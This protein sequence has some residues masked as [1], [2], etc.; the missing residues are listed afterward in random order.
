MFKKFKSNKYI[1]VIS[2]VIYL[3]LCIV[4][5]SFGSVKIPFTHTIRVILNMLFN[6]GDISD[7]PET[8]ITIITNI[9]LPR[10][11]MASIV[12]S[13]LSLAG[14]VMQGLLKNPLADGSSLGVASGASIGATIAIALGISLPIFSEFSI[15]IT[16]IIFAFISLFLVLFAVKKI[17]S[18]MSTNTVILAGVIFSMFASSISSLILA[19]FSNDTKKIVFWTLGSLASSNMSKVLLILP[20][21]L[22]CVVYILSKTSELNVFQIGEEGAK[23]LGVNTKKTKIMLF[24]FSSA[25][26]GMSVSMTGNIG[27]VGLI[28]PAIVR[29]IVKT[30]YKLILPFSMVIGSSFL[31]LTDL[32]SRTVVSPSELPIGTVTSLFGAVIFVYI[33]YNFK[34]RKEVS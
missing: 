33:L 5:I 11:I 14:A 3:I 26:V 28:I 20:I 15:I 24:I 27:F 30:D 13:S 10:I 7:I 22:I 4:S 6:I 29:M 1:F 23:Y 9:R 8:I 2:I 19:V 31:C 18:K 17:D 25:L 34:K 21:F 32:I 12:G 16:S